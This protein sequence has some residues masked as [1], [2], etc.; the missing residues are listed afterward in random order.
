MLQTLLITFREGLE[1]FL[2]IAISLIYLSQTGR[3]ELIPAVYGGVALALALSA[4]LGVVL[5][6][7]GALSPFW[8]GVMALLAAASV[9]YCTVHMM[10]VGRLMK[11][12]ITEGFNVASTASSARTWVAAFMFSAFMVGREGVETATM[13]ASL[14]QQA[15]SLD[16]ATG[17]VIG[18]LLAALLAGAWVKFGR[19]VNLHRFFQLTAI[20]MV[21]FA[22]QLVFAAFHEFT[23]TNSVP[24]VDNAWWHIATEPWGPEGDYGRLLSYSLGILPLAWMIYAYVAD[25]RNSAQRQAA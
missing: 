1:A 22:I 19:R 13:I 15:E 2:V 17:G 5:A 24:L 4:M 10:R 16:M 14:A 6:R 20:F 3:R 25:R 12:Q 23:E 9:I 21:A 7:I 8:E 18:V 11:Q